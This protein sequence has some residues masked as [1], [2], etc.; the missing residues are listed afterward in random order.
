[1]QSPASQND[2]EALFDDDFQD[3]TENTP[4]PS[5][6]SSVHPIDMSVDGTSQNESVPNTQENSQPVEGERV[7]DETWLQRFRLKSVRKYILHQKK[8]SF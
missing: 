8:V 1:M 6:E 5:Q 4:R 3:A 2:S 7:S